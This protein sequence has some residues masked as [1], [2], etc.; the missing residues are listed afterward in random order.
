ME[1][2]RH[3]FSFDQVSIYFNNCVNNGSVTVILCL[4]MQGEVSRAQA[5]AHSQSCATCCRR[6][7]SVLCSCMIW[8]LKA[9]LWVVTL[10]SYPNSWRR[11]PDTPGL[12]LRLLFCPI[13]YLTWGLFLLFYACP[14]L[15]IRSCYNIECLP[16]WDIFCSLKD[17]LENWTSYFKPCAACDITLCSDSDRRSDS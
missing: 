10:G 15:T 16:H 3:V 2:Q 6:C 11:S 5:E 1:S 17:W 12:L 7:G 8:L 13:R 4:W 9:I 14:I